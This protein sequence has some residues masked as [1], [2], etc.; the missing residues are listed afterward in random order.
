[1]AAESI[2]NPTGLKSCEIEDKLTDHDK[3]IFST[4]FNKEA[5][6]LSANLDEDKGEFNDSDEGKREAKNECG[7]NEHSYNKH[8]YNEYLESNQVNGKIYKENGVEI[9]LSLFP[10]VNISSIEKIEKFEG[11]EKRAIKNIENCDVDNEKI[12]KDIN[13]EE[14]SIEGFISTNVSKD[15]N[16]TKI[17]ES[18][19]ILE[20]IFEDEEGESYGS[21]FNNL[22]QM[23]R[24]Y[25]HFL[26]KEKEEKKGSSILEMRKLERDILNDLKRAIELTLPKELKRD[27]MNER[28]NQGII[29]ELHLQQCKVSKM[30]SK[31]LSSAYLQYATMLICKSVKMEEDKEEQ[32]KIERLAS[33]YMFIGGMF[34]NEISK[35]VS[36]KINPYGKL[37]G[38]IVKEAIINEYTDE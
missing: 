12:L 15:I 17:Q 20:E 35:R 7:Y 24:L 19:E 37:C 1:M 10:D 5:A 18:I 33:E 13:N 30:Q 23:K 27:E 32:M 11:I 14:L 2:K 21:V 4:I 22:A 28:N 26:E 8:S 16:L 36:M 25:L 38:D 6:G 9:D 34:G 3:L 29:E 31:V